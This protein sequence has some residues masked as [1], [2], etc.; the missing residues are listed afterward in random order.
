MTDTASPHTQ[1]AVAFLQM[2]VGGDVHAAYRTYTSPEMRLHNVYVAEAAVLEQAVA[3]D[4]LAHPHKRLA[5]HMTL[6]EGDRVMV[7]SHLHMTEDDAGYI[8]VH[9][10]RFHED[11]IAELWD[12][13][14]PIPAHSPW[15]F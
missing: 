9:I 1:I 10:F 13:G 3:D 8:M 14:Q 6:E 15:T 4:R 5:V 2:V 12:L 11:R 7:L